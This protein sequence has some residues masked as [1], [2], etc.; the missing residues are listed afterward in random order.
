M[1]YSLVDQQ[2]TPLYETGSGPDRE[3][4]IRS[5]L[6]PSPDGNFIALSVTNMPYDDR[7]VA[8]LYPDGEIHRIPNDYRFSLYPL[9]V[10]PLSE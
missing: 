2:M 5:P 7:Q 4:Y 10:P 6:I 9:W 1:R 8:V 3:S